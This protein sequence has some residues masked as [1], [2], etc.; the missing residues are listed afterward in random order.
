MVH[1]VNTPGIRLRMIPLGLSLNNPTHCRNRLQF[2]R[3]TPMLFPQLYAVSVPARATYSH[4]ASLNKRYV[5]PVRLGEPTNIRLCIFPTHID[6]RIDHSCAYLH[7]PEYS[8]HSLLP[9]IQAYHS[10]KCHVIYHRSQIAR[11]AMPYHYTAAFHQRT[12]LKRFV[13]RHS[14]ISEPDVHDNHLGPFSIGAFKCIR[15]P[16]IAEARPISPP[17]ICCHLYVGTLCRINTPIH[18]QCDTS[19]SPFSKGGNAIISSKTLY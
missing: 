14:S 7:H 19:V 1:I 5:L 10:F 13:P 16:L 12:P 2:S 4:S 6:H 8:F 9:S 17:C 3:L 15:P 11:A 18:V